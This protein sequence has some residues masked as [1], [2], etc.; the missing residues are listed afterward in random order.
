MTAMEFFKMSKSLKIYPT[1]VPLDVLKKVVL[2]HQEFWGNILTPDQDQQNGDFT[3]NDFVK[4]FRIISKIGYENV[5]LKEGAKF[6]LL[7]QYLQKST[8][9]SY[10]KAQPKELNQNDAKSVRSQVTSSALKLLN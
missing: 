9:S 7:S 3:F 1:I 6:V 8:G 4:A 10:G 2:K 5:N